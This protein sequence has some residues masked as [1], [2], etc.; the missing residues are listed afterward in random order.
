M[1]FFYKFASALIVPWAT[2]SYATGYMSFNWLAATY[3]SV[4]ITPLTL[5]IFSRALNRMT[6]YI[7]MEKNDENI[8]IGHFTTFLKLKQE[9]IP[10]EDIIPE[11]AAVKMGRNIQGLILSK[12]S[13]LSEWF[14]L[15][16]NGVK[17]FD[18]E[19]AERILRNLDEF[20]EDVYKYK[21]D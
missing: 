19:K 3:G 16:S 8:L 7:L 15:P 11:K 13:N 12:K 5:Y 2:Y 4:L 20:S 17:I 18:K 14:Y 9:V 6:A 21:K 10:I 1:K